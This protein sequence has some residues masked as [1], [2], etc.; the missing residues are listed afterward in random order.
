MC[1]GQC[2]WARHLLSE[3]KSED[4]TSR[5]PWFVLVSTAAGSRFLPG[6]PLYLV[7]SEKTVHRA[8]QDFDVT[9]YFQGD[10]WSS[11]LWRY[12]EPQWVILP[13]FCA[14]KNEKRYSK[15]LLFFYTFASFWAPNYF[16][17]AQKKGIFFSCLEK[18][19][20][21]FFQLRK[22]AKYFFHAKK[23]GLVFSFLSSEKSQKKFTCQGT[24]NKI[25]FFVLRKEAK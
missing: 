17:R 11:T 23:R 5:R 12:G 2:L 25:F 19:Q 21:I 3:S 10:F 15:W 6:L 13:I 7:N 14:W 22:K 9:L 20:N 4:H 18:R 16:F 8:L 1:S 24:R